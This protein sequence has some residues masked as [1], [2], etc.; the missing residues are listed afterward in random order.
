MLGGLAVLLV[1]TVGLLLARHNPR[2]PFTERVAVQMVL[3]DPGSA[4][5]LGSLR[6]D[7]AAIGAVDASLER[8]AFFEGPQIVFQAAVQ[9]DGRVTQ[10][11]DFVGRAA[12]YGSPL[13]YEPA[14]LVGLS[15]LCLLAAGVAP[16]RRRRNLDALALLSFVA[17]VVLLQ[18]R[19]VDWSVLAALPG[20]IYLLVRCLRV[21][22]GP[23]QPVQPSTSLYLALTRNWEPG[24]RLRVLRMAIGALAFVV[25]AVGVSS[26]GA[27]DVIYGVMEGGTKL[28]HGVLPY[29]H[30]P[31]DVVHGDTYPLLSYALYAPIAALSPVSSTWDS[32]D[33]A[34]GATALSALL[35]AVVLIAAVT[36][37]PTLTRAET[38]SPTETTAPHTGRGSECAG[39]LA[40]LTWLSFPPLLITV[41]TGT[42]DVVLASI[43]VIALV[44]WRRPGASSAL[45]AC[46]GWFKLAPFALFPIWMAPLRGRRLAASVIALISVS[47]VMLAVLIGLGGTDGVSAMLHAIGFQFRRGSFQSPWA[48]LGLASFQPIGQAAVLALIAGVAIRLR[49]APELF[50]ER[51]RVA[52]ISAAILLSLQLTA[53]YWSFLYLVWIVPLVGLSLLATPEAARAPV[54]VRERRAHQVAAGPAW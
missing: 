42:T 36:R 3:R 9:S 14:V 38:V 54:A 53:D 52:A 43:L 32:V 45:L 20:L 49:R 50:A 7:R 35:T 40:A 10:S 6:W 16:L 11:F 4:N 25:I 37:G 47:A 12:P 27:V 34:L 17:P 2:V 33:V 39:L 41:S 18:L 22:I 21:G 24:A 29:G 51:E 48:A 15:V 19:F 5:A 26:T 13:A 23:P 8:V 44:L 1:A 46:A 28:L 30:L 31:G